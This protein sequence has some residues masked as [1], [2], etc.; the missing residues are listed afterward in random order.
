VLAAGS[1]SGAADGKHDGN[2]CMG[3]TD[4]ELKNV[5]QVLDLV[6]PLGDNPE[7]AV[8]GRKGDLVQLLSILD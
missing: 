7:A 5:R 2:F 3:D 1:S 6:V 8:Q 4:F